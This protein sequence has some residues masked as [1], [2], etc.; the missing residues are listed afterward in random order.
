MKPNAEQVRTMD[1]RDL[2]EMF[3]IG[4]EEAK[5]LK[6]VQQ[7]RDMIET[8]VTP[9]EGKT[10]LH[11][12]LDLITHE[13]WVRPEP[14]H[15]PK[16]TLASSID[17]LQISIRS[18]HCLRNGEPHWCIPSITTVGELIKYSANDLFKII[19]FGK[20]SLR[21]IEEVLADHGLRLSLID[22]AQRREIT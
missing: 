11:Y 10:L 20:R 9:D 8:L 13:T 6:K 17:E 21:E 14:Q 12:V 2:R 16:L 3:E 18:Y 1:V 22:K 19:N 5:R 4:M 7:C 15:P